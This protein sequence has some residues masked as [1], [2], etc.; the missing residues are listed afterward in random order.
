MLSKKIDF[1]ASFLVVFIKRQKATSVEE[2]N[3]KIFYGY[4]SQA[5]CEFAL[6][7]F[8]INFQL[9]EQRRAIFVKML[10]FIGEK[11]L[12]TFSAELSLKRPPSIL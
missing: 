2:E 8:H 11:L 9:L 4:F 3:N 12:K 1:I 6:L 7:I 10:S 5:I